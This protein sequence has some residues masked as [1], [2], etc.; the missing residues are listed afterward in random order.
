M[1]AFKITLRTFCL[2]L[3]KTHFKYIN[4][5]TLEFCFLYF[6]RPWTCNIVARGRTLLLVSSP[7]AA[8]WVMLLH[9][10]GAPNLNVRVAPLHL[11]PSPPCVEGGVFRVIACLPL[12]RPLPGRGVTACCQSWPRFSPRAQHLLPYKP[13]PGQE[14]LVAHGVFFVCRRHS[15]TRVSVRALTADLPKQVSPSGRNMHGIRHLHAC[16]M[17]GQRRGVCAAVQSWAVCRPGS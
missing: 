14:G 9:S 1:C 7:M 17:A 15:R 12:S 6:L 3:D 2:Y 10:V 11:G 13:E 16:K 5:L 4:I 8:L